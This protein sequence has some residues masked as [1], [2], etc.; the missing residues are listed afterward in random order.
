ML[1]IKICPTCNAIFNEGKWVFSEPKKSIISAVKKE[2]KIHKEAKNID[3]SVFLEF[4][5]EYKI[6][7]YI[8]IKSKISG[9]DLEDEGEV[10]IRLKKESCKRC[11]RISSGYYESIIQIRAKERLPTQN[12]VSRC[13]KIAHGIV[14]SMEKKDPLAFISKIE[15]LK[16]GLDIYVGSTSVAR[17][18][19]KSISQSLGGD[20]LES[21]KLVSQQG[22]KKLYR[23]T[24][25]VRLPRFVKGDIILLDD[26][27]ILIEGQRKK[28]KGLDLKTG[29]NYYYDVKTL[30][31]ASLICNEIDAKKTVVCAWDE[32]EIQILDPENYKQA[33]I[34]KPLFF[35]V[36]DNNEV[37]VIKCSKGVFLV[38]KTKK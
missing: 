2:L 34:L 36:D 26:K 13:K 25:S 3:I 12:E 7:A 27:V 17:Q 18:I 28:I 31:G 16:R 8:K 38:P 11:S 4:L 10:E 23:V 22:G 1:V 20:I 21:P 30:E 35:A 19:V 6:L 29:L 9:F 24:F 37:Y 14:E 32:R 33:T 5:D 15:M